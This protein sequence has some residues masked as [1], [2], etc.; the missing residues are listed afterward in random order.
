M[1]R[2]M[3]APE[4]QRKKRRVGGGAPCE[5]RKTVTLILFYV[6]VFCTPLLTGVTPCAEQ[7]DVAMTAC[8]AE[9]SSGEVVPTAVCVKT[10]VHICPILKDWFLDFAGDNRERKQWSMAHSVRVAR[11]LCPLFENIHDDA[12]RKWKYSSAPSSS[13]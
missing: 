5:S 12:P 1:K 2:Q 4:E 9:G 10:K 8:A 11:R 3:E 6:L 7:V 13:P